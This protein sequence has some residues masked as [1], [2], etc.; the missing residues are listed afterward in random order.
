M[1]LRAAASKSNELLTHLQALA[2]SD[3][4]DEVALRRVAAQARRLMGSDPAAAHVALGTVEALVGNEGATKEHYRVALGL[5]SEAPI[6]LNYATSLAFL[7]DHAA[8]L[9]VAREGLKMHQGNLPLVE[10]AI[11][12]AVRSGQFEVAAELCRY[13]DRLGA[14]R[15][16]PRG[17]MVRSLKAAVANGAM[18][19]AGAQGLIDALTEVQQTEGVRTAST[20]LL[21]DGETFLYQRH[22]RCTPGKACSM[23]WQL[24][25][26][27]VENP[28]LSSDPGRVLIGGFVGVANGRNA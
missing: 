21:S 23:N 3:M 4:L 25:G 5:S 11:D 9:D 24:A 26:T 27:V 10:L 17:D 18:S 22:V 14:E 15:P 8:S 12:A 19:E 1:A 16:Y 7:D 2:R 20:H 13:R 6:W 28:G